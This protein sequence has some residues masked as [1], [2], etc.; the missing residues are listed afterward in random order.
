[1]TAA[2]LIE[3]RITRQLI[4]RRSK[5]AEAEYF[6]LARHARVHSWVDRVICVLAVTACLAVVGSYAEQLL[7]VILA[8]ASAIALRD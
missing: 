3:Y 8:A 4:R 5:R 1:M 6:S 7:W 2:R